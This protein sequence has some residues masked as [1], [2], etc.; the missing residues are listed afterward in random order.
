VKLSEIKVDPAKIEAGAWVDGIPEFE[1]VRLKVRG[2]GCKEQQKLSRA[3]FDA[4]PRSRRPKGK[5]SQEDQDRILDRCLHE[6][7]L[8]DWDGLQND[9]DTPMPYDKA[10]ALTFITDP[11]FRKF[12]DAVV[13]AA[14]TIANDKAEAVEATVGNSQ[15]SSAGNSPGEPASSI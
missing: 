2:L 13:W 1:G 4:I 11:A 15:P 14:D 6:V 12:R 5:V 9:D 8:L 7:I 10:K 3:L